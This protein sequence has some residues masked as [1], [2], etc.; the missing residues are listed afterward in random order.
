[1]KIFLTAEGVLLRQRLGPA[2][3]VRMSYYGFSAYHGPALLRS[4]SPFIPS[5]HHDHRG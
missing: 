3:W 1:M 5:A 2:D 4:R